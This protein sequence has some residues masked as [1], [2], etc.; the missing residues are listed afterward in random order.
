[1]E[2]INSGVFKSKIYEG[3]VGGGISRDR[4]KKG[5]ESL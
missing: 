4:E 3:E 2:T 1:M 5:K